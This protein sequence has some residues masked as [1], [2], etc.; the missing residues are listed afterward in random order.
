[1][2]A[3]LLFV[4]CEQTP[5]EEQSALVQLPEEYWASFDG[6]S[7]TYLDDEVR[8][9]WTED[10]RLTVFQ[11]TTYA[12][13]FAFTGHTGA[14][15]GGFR[16]KSVD[17]PYWYG[18]DLA[19]T[20][21]IYPHSEDTWFH[22]RDMYMGVILPA[23]QSY[24]ENSF[25]LGANTMV[26]VT[27]DLEDN[28]LIFKNVCSYLRVMLWGENQTVKKVTFSSNAGE[29]VAGK[30]QVYASNTA[31][32]TTTM[33]DE[34]STI[35]LT[36]NE[37]VTVNTTEDAPVAFWIVVPPVVLSKGY[38]VTVENAEGQ[39][40]VYAVN[41]EK[42][43][44]RNVYNT[45]QRELT[46]IPTPAANEIWYTSTDGN[47]VE[48][49]RTAFP[50]NPIHTNNYADGKGVITFYGDITKIGNDAF[51]ECK[52]LASLT[53]PE[54]VT[55]IEQYAFEQCTSLTNISLPKTITIIGAN[56]FAN[57]TNLAAISIPKDVT[58]IEEYTFANCTS[59]TSITLPEGIT[60]IGRYAFSES[61]ITAI[62]IPAGVTTIED[63]TF[64]GCTALESV[65]LPTSVTTIKEYAFHHSK[66]A[67]ITIPEGVTS[68]EKYT[69]AYCTNLAKI[70][71]PEGVTSIGE[72]A[73]HE[74]HGLVKFSLPNSL[75]TIDACAFSGCLTLESVTIPEK[76]E[77]I[78]AM[79][80]YGCEKLS[81][82]Y[83][84]PLQVPTGGSQMF[85][86]I[87]DRAKIYVPNAALYT[88]KLLEYWN[89][90]AS[91]M[92]GYLF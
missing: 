18:D 41:K 73:F 34:I 17:D 72:R 54:G 16:Q 86:N 9:L 19:T 3:A 28:R 11:G 60:T 20:Y 10:D 48:P 15:A 61:G 66:L 8:M 37:P 88:Y 80:F 43:F 83:C 89:A 30:A 6:D 67:N 2:L 42:T 38:T 14:N 59:L 24:V 71:I 22:E 4:G 92:E 74:C 51:K 31:D 65:V 75:K 79:A 81:S 90:Y 84:Q 23:E 55:T 26:A 7:R 69:F 1:M 91:I 64:Y 58:K 49:N 39:T 29:C 50:S 57:C 21:A 82:I 40:Q 36:C 53:L 45:L 13:E 46:Y 32:P 5:I 78:G 76:V 25:G 87:A 47:I 63:Y 12:R 77:A 52:T 33:V 27:K 56:A 85:D 70:T 62:S 68:I 44:K 35:T